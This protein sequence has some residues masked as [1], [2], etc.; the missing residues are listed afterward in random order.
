M[1]LIHSVNKEF[2][3]TLGINGN[4]N[5]GI[6]KPKLSLNECG[7]WDSNP[8]AGGD[9]SRSP[10]FSISST[11]QGGLWAVLSVVYGHG[12]EVCETYDFEGRS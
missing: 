9:V 7:G 5:M 2:N 8:M 10:F 6:N 3:P 4:Q 11:H 12:H 1:Y